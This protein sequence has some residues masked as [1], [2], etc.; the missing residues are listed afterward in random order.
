V[1][2][3]PDAKD[4][5]IAALTPPSASLNL[6]PGGAEAGQSTHQFV[7]GV[8][9][10]GRYRMVAPLGAGGA[11]EVWRADD[12]V[13]QTPVALKV[14]PPTAAH[15]RAR[16]L[17]EV[18][19]ARQVT[20][21]SVCRVFDVGEAEGC[22]FY[23]M[24]LVDGE[25]LATLL[26][27]A[28]T[29]PVEKVADIANQLCD[30]L[31]TAHA[32]RIVHGNLK[33]A[34]VLLDQ[35]GFVRVT[36]FGLTL[37]ERSH[38]ADAPYRAPELQSPG[39]QP[40]ERTDLFAAGAILY[41]LLT[42]SP[43]AVSPKGGANRA[44]T[45]ARLAPGIDL[46]FARG[47][48]AALARDPNQRPASA[49]TLAERL[50]GGEAPRRKDWGWMA[51]AVVLL[52]V[53][54]A[55]AVHL[56][57]TRT[58]QQL[59]DRDT[60]VVADFT[61]STGEAVFDGA[62]K[63]ALAVAL[64]QSP[65]LKVVPDERMRETLRLME[66]S[67]DEPITRALA[68]EIAAREQSRA[69][70]AGSIGKLGSHYVLTL[71]ALNAQSNEVIARE[72]IEVESQ[73]EVLGALGTAAATLRGRLGESLASVQRFDVPLA[74]ATTSSLEAL[75]A[76]S[77]ALDEGRMNLRN[78]A[79]PHLERAL[80]IDPQFALAQAMLSGIF[81]NN[82][83]SAEAPTYSR[84]AFELRD[85]VSE[86][87][88]FFISWR[89]YI[90][91]AQAWDQALALAASWTRTYPR[92]AFAFNSLGLATGSFGNHELA[93]EAY[94]TAIGLDPRFVAPRGNLVGSL[95][96]SN[97]YDEARAAIR[98]AR[99]Q[100]INGLSQYRAT[101]ALA[102]VANDD[103]AMASAL[104]DARNSPEASL[105]SLNWEAHTF[106]FGGQL[107]QAHLMFQRA[108]QE[109]VG[110]NQRERAAQWEAEDA[111]SHA[112]A[113][114]CELARPEVA[115]ALARSRDNYTIERAARTLAVCGD[116]AA[117]SV[118][119]AELQQRFP[120][121]TLTQQ[122]HLPVLNAILAL[123]TDP[124]RAVDR[125][126]A[127]RPYDGAPAAEFWPEYVRGLAYL[128]LKDG[129]KAALAFQGILDHRGRLPTSGLYPLAVL[130]RARAAVLTGET[131][132]ARTSYE[133][134]F[135]L[136]KQADT[137]LAPVDEARREYAALR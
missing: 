112:L 65:F 4:Y 35:D 87:E 78:E 75:N 124:A 29:L 79:I 28:G 74:R 11:G 100:G 20:H 118:L 101:Y 111:E 6:P 19:L 117:A 71:E 66:R 45:L 128:G 127:V 31:A 104:S 61:N 110:A 5:A 130:G 24:E 7:A 83:R 105:P 1:P 12:L 96:A 50:R 103:A 40:T 23:S 134:F 21:P 44:R 116:D 14:L 125:L 114:Q 9:F 122:I 81:Y 54:T 34:N 56:F 3:R 47:V 69:L 53:L 2:D 17:D 30:A 58:P 39:G 68:R 13:L 135:T 109:A 131:I 113:G 80:E 106:G 91:S 8:L 36:D 93:I 18:R 49:V 32:Q 115:S 43:P 133:Q 46:H 51:A 136:L 129:H 126:N 22:V 64:E 123:R 42:G 90:D 72:Q 137:H 48:A 62:L 102:V 70:V 25:D 15:A 82:G 77:L 121:A 108:V 94:R 10:A 27:R 85:R 107:R 73:E 57:S 132:Q 86:R 89:Y 67:P 63:V 98:E 120:D 99:Q 33:P 119:T 37:E 84:R 52:A 55:G 26:R 38:D 41:E 97:Q 76:Y 88:R 95:L 16:I 92:E 59:S 60:M